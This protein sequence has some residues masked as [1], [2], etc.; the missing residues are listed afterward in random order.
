MADELNKKKPDLNTGNSTMSSK[1]ASEQLKPSRTQG[2]Q[3]STNVNKSPKIENNNKNVN[4]VNSVNN[5]QQPKSNPKQFDATRQKIVNQGFAP[6]FDA[7]Q[8]FKWSEGLSD[9]DNAKINT[10]L[11]NLATYAGDPDLSRVN[12]EWVDDLAYQLSYEGYDDDEIHRLI[13]HFDKTAPT[14]EEAF[15]EYKAHNEDDS[16]QDS[17]DNQITNIEAQLTDLENRVPYGL[18][19]KEQQM[20]KELEGQLEQLKSKRQTNERD[21]RDQASKLFGTD[22]SNSSSKREKALSSLTEDQRKNG[23]KHPT[24]GKESSDLYF[25]NNYT[26]P[27]YSA[28]E[29]LQPMEDPNDF[30]QNFEE[31][32]Y[33]FPSEKK[34]SRG[35]SMIGE[36]KF[37][38]DADENVWDALREATEN[39]SDTDTVRDIISKAS[40]ESGIDEDRLLNALIFQHLYLGNHFAFR[41]ETNYKK[42]SAKQDEEYQKYLPPQWRKK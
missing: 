12:N 19:M 3:F 4:N 42:L 40:K 11:H 24:T 41:P 1:T 33:R 30:S 29:G 39:A 32:F 34:G 6:K 26:G 31:S 27:G 21:E 15:P 22:L 23:F 37:Y 5:K 10:A 14:Y 28:F 2:G 13:D 8:K 17:L 16:D 9:E 38:E 25:N 20:Q 35:R 18:T 7:T 36:Q